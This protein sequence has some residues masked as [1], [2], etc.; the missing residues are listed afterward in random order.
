MKRSAFTLV[1]LIFVIVIIGVLAAVAVPKYKSLEDN[2][3]IGNVAKF[4]GD[5]TSSVKGSY[6]NSVTL[7]E[8]NTSD[9]NMS[10]LYDFQGKGWSVGT[11][12]ANYSAAA[13]DGNITMRVVYNNAGQLDINITVA[14]ATTKTK[15]AQ[16]TGLTFTTGSDVNTT[17]INLAE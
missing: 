12:D 4:Y 5:I 6:M 16:K 11:D 2:A 14:G 1:E 10:Q 8:L 17:V 15:L 7:N 3:K 13:S 9:V